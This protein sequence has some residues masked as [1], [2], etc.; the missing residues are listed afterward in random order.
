M[1][2]SNTETEPKDM[3]LCVYCGH[4]EFNSDTGEYLEC[5]RCGLIIAHS[6]LT[7]VNNALAAERRLH[8]DGASNGCDAGEI[9]ADEEETLTSAWQLMQAQAWEKALA[10]LVPAAIPSQHPLEFAVWRGICRTAPALKEKNLKRR[11][12]LLEILQNNLRRLNYFLPACEGEKRYRLLQ[13][14]FQGVM[15]LGMQ[16]AECLTYHSII[17]NHI[18]TT[19]RRRADMLIFLAETLESQSADA[20]YGTEYLKMSVQLYRQCL[21]TA[22]EIC[23]VNSYKYGSYICVKENQ[24]Q[25]PAAVRRHVD[26]KIS[27][28]NE[29]IVRKDPGFTP[30]HDLPVPRIMPLW[31]GWTLV[32]LICLLG[33]ALTIA[34]AM[35]NS[36][37]LMFLAIFALTI[38]ALRIVSEY[39]NSTYKKYFD[40]LRPPKDIGTI[41]K[42]DN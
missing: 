40:N 26:D 23:N 10:A 6:E 3:E 24:L 5:R 31:L 39:D 2:N 37:I 30:K 32:P 25:I 20:A 33:A 12:F 34:S 28:L 18:D 4:N 27:R 7:A 8:A 42:N 14:L 36:L 19:N 11:V 35:L 1:L 29:S 16:D 13:K 17:V 9:Y 38:I 15:L 41:L 22:H 21:I